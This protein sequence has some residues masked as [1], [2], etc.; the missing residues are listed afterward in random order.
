MLCD[1]SSSRCADNILDLVFKAILLAL[2]NSSYEIS[3]CNE[4]V[5]ILLLL[6]LHIV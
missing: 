2:L 6:T 1:T 3:A 4:I 5:Q